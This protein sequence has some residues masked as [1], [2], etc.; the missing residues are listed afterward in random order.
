MKKLR[1]NKNF[2]KLVWS[3]VVLV[4]S[5]ATKELANIWREFAPL[6]VLVIREIVKYINVNLLWDL[7]VE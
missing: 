4:L 2:R 7:W 3:I 1:Q 5:Y 6:L